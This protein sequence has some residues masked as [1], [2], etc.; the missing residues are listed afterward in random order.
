MVYT[1]RWSLLHRG[2]ADTDAAASEPVLLSLG[3]AGSQSEARERWL[4]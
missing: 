2:H 1:G 4:S 3:L